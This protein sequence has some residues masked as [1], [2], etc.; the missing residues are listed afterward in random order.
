LTYGTVAWFDPQRGTG[1]ITTDE[2]E[3]VVP[4]YATDIDGGGRQSLRVTDRVAFTLL[5]GPR[6]P[7]ALRV[8]MP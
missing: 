3:Q 5:D 7:Q 6:G 2:D 1:G 8:W 4:V